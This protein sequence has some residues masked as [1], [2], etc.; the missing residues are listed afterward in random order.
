VV[1]LVLNEYE[2]KGKEEKKD[3]EKK[4]MFV[5]VISYFLNNGNLFYL[6]WR[7]IFTSM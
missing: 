3:K 1:L 7:Y 2:E 4:H 6:E 5:C